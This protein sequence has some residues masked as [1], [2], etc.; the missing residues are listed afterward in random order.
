[1]NKIK[2][3]GILIKT[4]PGEYGYA[5][6][7]LL[8]KRPGQDDAFVQFVLDTVLD[9]SIMVKS[10]VD[11]EGYVRG[12]NA[13]DADGKWKIVQYPKATSVKLAKS[14]F[15]T[16]FGLEGHFPPKH[17]LDIF[18]DATVNAIIPI[19]NDMRFLGLKVQGNSTVPET[20]S[21][22][23]RRSNRYYAEWNALEKGDTVSCWIN[24]RT[25]QKIINGV[26][27]GFV[28]FEIE[29]F[30]ITNKEIEREYRKIDG[31][32]PGE[33]EKIVRKK[34]KKRHV[35]KRYY[36]NRKKNMANELKAEPDVEIKK[37]PEEKTPV[38]NSSFFDETEE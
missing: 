2:A 17:Q 4:G 37:E 14:V 10:V 32:K 33:G 23:L 11:V 34:N 20:I 12:Y 25:P 22:E 19:N 3:T 38:T 35:N 16:E 9:P 18:V 7:T 15:E 36:K 29:D 26:S 30:A 27:K 21:V 8:V 24:V 28:N 31:S 6:I 13:Q 5:S 1:M